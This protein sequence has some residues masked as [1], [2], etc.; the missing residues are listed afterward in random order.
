MQEKDTVLAR[1]SF[2]SDWFWLLYILNGSLNPDT[3]AI[4]GQFGSM[5]AS[6]RDTAVLGWQ[7]ELDQSNAH[8]LLSP[9]EP[10]SFEQI[11]HP[12]HVVSHLGRPKLHASYSAFSKLARN[13]Q[14]LPGPLGIN[15]RTRLKLAS[16]NQFYK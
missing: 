6:C 2:S 14:S 16:L 12:P 7:D 4:R 11:K 5:Y 1:S 13:T 10:A 9:M 8:S 3:P 15:I